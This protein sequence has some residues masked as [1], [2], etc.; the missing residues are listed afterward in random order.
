MNHRLVANLG[1]VTV[2]LT[3]CGGSGDASAPAEITPSGTPS[4]TPAT[5]PAGVPTPTPTPPGAP[6]PS[7]TP[8]VTITPTPSSP[9]AVGVVSGRFE[10]ALP[11]SY[12]G[13]YNSCVRDKITGLIW[14]GKIPNQPY[15]WDRAEK[16][17]VFTNF[18]S[19]SRLEYAQP[20]AGGDVSWKYPYQWEIDRDDRVGA[21]GHP[22]GWWT[23]TLDASY[24]M[25]NTTSYL[26]MVNSRNFCGFSNWRIPTQAELSSLLNDSYEPKIDPTWFP[27]TARGNYWTVEDLQGNWNAYTNVHWGSALSFTHD[28]YIFDFAGVGRT[29]RSKHHHLRLVRN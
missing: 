29:H 23:Y 25:G 27:N 26:N 1:L 16:G 11:A 3:A 20:I 19:T 21:A 10:S 18:S 6:V 7:P 5:S 12:S 17:G 24:F 14:E 8:G 28:P 13:A 15:G 22:Y 2:L 4:P 9:P